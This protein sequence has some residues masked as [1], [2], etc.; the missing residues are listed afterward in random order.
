MDEGEGRDATSVCPQDSKKLKP[1]PGLGPSPSPVPNPNPSGSAGAWGGRSR[2]PGVGP[3]H[4]CTVDGGDRDPPPYRAAEPQYL[5]GI[6]TS[7]Q[8]MGP[9]ARFWIRKSESESAAP[10]V[11]VV[12][13]G[14]YT[15]IPNPFPLAIAPR[16]P[17]DVWVI[18]ILLWMK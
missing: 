15:P 7:E 13:Y 10:V 8:G 18:K 2:G 16:Q 12:V 11:V 9:L 4:P 1:S 14:R 3:L 5:V 17:C 6:C